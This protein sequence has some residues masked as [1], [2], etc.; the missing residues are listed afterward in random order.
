MN[1][2]RAF[3]G[4][5]LK[6]VKKNGDRATLFKRIGTGIQSRRHRATAAGAMTIGAPPPGGGGGMRAQPH[7][8]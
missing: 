4:E 3:H 6:Q 7:H 2:Q 5:Q 8:R 1:G